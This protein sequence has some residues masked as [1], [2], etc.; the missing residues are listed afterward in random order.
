MRIALFICGILLFIAC[1]RLPIGYYMVLR[2]AVATGAGLVIINEYKGGFSLWVVVFGLIAIVFNP[3][4]PVYLQKK[5]IWI[6]IDIICGI[7]FIAKSFSFSRAK[8]Q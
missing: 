8:T 3:L 7:L 1:A 6:P 4:F 2:I 5:S